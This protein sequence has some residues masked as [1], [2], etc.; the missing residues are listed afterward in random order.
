MTYLLA[1][2]PVE[3][4]EE[5]KSAFDSFDPFRTEHGQQGYQVFQSAEEPNEVVVLF[6]WDDD[7]LSFFRSDEMR[8]RMAQAGVKGQPDMTALNFVEQKSASRPSA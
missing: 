8:E 4:F 2:A 1:K 7:P 5:W 3:S 6:E